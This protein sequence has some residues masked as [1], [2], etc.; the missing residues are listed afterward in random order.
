MRAAILVLLLGSVAASAPAAAAPVAE[1][2]VPFDRYFVDHTMRVDL[3]HV[4]N[5]SEELFTLDRVYEQGIWA[6]SRTRLLDTLGT[7]NYLAKLYDASSG[8][9][10]YSRAYD[11]YFGEYRTTTEAGK[12]VRRAYQESVLTPFP[13][14]RARLVIERRQRDRSLKP[15]F[16]TEIDPAAYTVVRG[17]LSEGVIVVEALKGG[18]PHR[19]VDLAVIGEGY[20]AAEEGKFRK[21]LDRVVGILF[22]QQPYARNKARFNVYGVLKPSQESGCNEPA[23]GIHRNTA[24]GASFDSLGS[25]RYMLTEENRA[26]QDIAAHVPH[27]ALYIMVD[28]T[29]YGGGGIY[30]FFCAFTSDNQ[31]TP[32]LLL[33]EFG[34]AFAGLADEYYTSS[35]AYN[36]FYPK[37]VEPTE[38]NVTALLD[39]ANLKW[40]DL[41]MPGTA[42][43]TPWEKADY[44]AMDIA[45][46]KVREELNGR[47]AKAMR[48]GA[49]QADVDKLKAEAED[50]SLEHAKKIDAFLAGSAFVGKVGA[51]EGG[52]YTSTGIYRPALD[53]IMFTKGSKP[54][55]PVCER[56]IE[57]AIEQYLE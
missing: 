8:A 38:A 24:V 35:V 12:G 44:D 3:V 34:H 49:P 11:S 17:A 57:R 25:E 32:Y 10:L 45:Y 7:G 23:R 9:L 51:F 19:C 36:D 28:H 27:D 54:F 14:A 5:S 13:K 50:L 47:I 30:N 33:H 42:L 52:G 29:R 1:P 4:G 37:G 18:D 31:W 56:A 40:K 2:A 26:L 55:C 20:T 6:G 16:E 39:P 21:D 41:V 53:C 48:E 46:Q 15:V 22:A 43:P